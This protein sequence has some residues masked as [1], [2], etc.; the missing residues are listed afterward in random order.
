LLLTE[1]LLTLLL[2]VGSELALIPVLVYF[3]RASR[4]LPLVLTCV[5]LNLFTHPLATLA[6]LVLG[7][8]LAHVEATVILVE[9]IG[10]WRI[11]GLSFG[12]SLAFSTA[13]NV[14]SMTA[15]F[16]LFR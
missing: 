10:Y 14:L 2:T 5:S 16:L 1:Y 4:R 15:G 8:S 13:A 3:N 11:A 12:K 6:H 9:A 7:I